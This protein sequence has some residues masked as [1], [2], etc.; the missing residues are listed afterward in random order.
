ML[1]LI[2]CL[3]KTVISECFSCTCRIFCWAL[4]EQTGSRHY[5][6]LPPHLSAIGCRLINSSHKN[7]LKDSPQSRPCRRYTGRYG[8]APPPAPRWAPGQVPGQGATWWFG[9]GL[10]NPE[11]QSHTSLGA[12]CIFVTQAR[13]LS[14]VASA[15]LQS[16]WKGPFPWSFVLMCIFT[17]LKLPSLHIEEEKNC[18]F[19]GEFEPLVWPNLKWY[20]KKQ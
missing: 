6:P 9:P 3:F 5:S 16:F 8:R 11:F 2:K 10:L 17:N 18:P 19:M 12:D 20:Y 13:C 4:L 7:V 15:L 14:S 1:F